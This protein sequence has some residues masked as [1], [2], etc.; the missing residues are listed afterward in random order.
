VPS[1]IGVGLGA[2]GVGLDAIGVAL[3]AI[4]VAIGARLERGGTVSLYSFTGAGSSLFSSHNYGPFW[5][6]LDHKLLL[7]FSTIR[8]FSMPNSSK[9]SD[10]FP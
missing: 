8:S 1:A 7:Q 5:D 6:N 3:D 4:G 10:A 9:S 2:I